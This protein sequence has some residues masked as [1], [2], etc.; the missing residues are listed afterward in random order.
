MAEVDVY[1]G[2]SVVDFSTEPPFALSS[3]QFGPNRANKTLPK[4]IS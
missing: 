4:H 3:L 1:S 2:R